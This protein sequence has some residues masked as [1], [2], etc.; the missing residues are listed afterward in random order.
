MNQKLLKSLTAWPNA[1]LTLAETPSFCCDLNIADKFFKQ[2][3]TWK[4]QKNI[5]KIIAPR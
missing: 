2:G 5:T 1:R 3:K 4:I